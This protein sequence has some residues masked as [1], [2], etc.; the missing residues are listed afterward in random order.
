MIHN[1]KKAPMNR[2]FCKKNTATMRNNKFDCQL[3]L[4]P[5]SSQTFLYCTSWSRLRLTLPSL[6]FF[7]NDVI[8]DWLRRLEVE[9]SSISA[10][11]GEFWEADEEGG[12]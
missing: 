9:L 1:S 5:L 3:V 6:I 4:L 10:Q 8:E 7:G 12:T 2:Y 11:F